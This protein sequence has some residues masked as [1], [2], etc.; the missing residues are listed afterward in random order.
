MQLY[1]SLR[2]T[3][4][5]IQ[6]IDD[7]V[8]MYVCGITPYDTSHMGHARTYV[9]FDTM[10]RLLEWQGL[11]VL[12]VQNVTDIDDD[13]LRKGAELGV[14]WDELGRRETESFLRNMAAINVAMPDHYVKATDSMPEIVE[15]VS[16]LIER[17]VA[18]EHNGSVY[19]SVQADPNFGS[20]AH[21]DYPTMLTTANERGNF[22]NDPNKRDP[23]DF[24]LWQA[25]KPGEPT[26]AS[27]WGEGRPG[28][29]IECTAMV[30]HYL[31]PRIN[32]HG[33]GGDLQFPHHACELAQAECY[34]GQTPHVEAWSHV[35]MVCYEGE[36]MSKSLGNLVLVSDT[37]K[38]HTADALRIALLKYPYREAYEYTDADVVWAEG[39]VARLQSAASSAVGGGGQ[40]AEELRVDMLNALDSDFNTPECIRLLIALAEAATNGEIDDAESAAA[41]I[42][43]VGAILGLSAEQW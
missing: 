11:P 15:I 24:V 2:R 30:L 33:G 16:G 21:S 17:G 3:L 32:I 10:R 37:L 4:V 29:H 9:V 31:G 22:P 23:L 42:R 1:D 38:E 13:V 20:M 14:A 39:V 5:P 26:W 40:S 7:V 6:P 28:W 12:Y 8:R 43:E 36:K 18:Y 41:T 34:S 25:A 19:F 27:P 35:G